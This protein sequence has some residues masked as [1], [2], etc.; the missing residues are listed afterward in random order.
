MV[1]CRARTRAPRSMTSNTFLHASMNWVRGRWCSC[2]FAKPVPQLAV[3]A[4]QR[5]EEKRQQACNSG[6]GDGDGG[7]NDDDDDDGEAS[8]TDLEGYWED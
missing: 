7:D 4:G 3:G 1:H 2:T 6:S 8:G 5:V